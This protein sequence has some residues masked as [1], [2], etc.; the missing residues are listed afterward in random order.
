MVKLLRDDDQRAAS[1]NQHVKHD[2]MSLR[3]LQA[4]G[5]TVLSPRCD[6]PPHTHTHSHTSNT[7]PRI[8][9]H[10]RTPRVTVCLETSWDVNSANTNIKTEWCHCWYWSHTPPCVQSTHTHTHTHRRC[11]LSK[12]TNWVP[13]KSVHYISCQRH[14]KAVWHSDGFSAHVTSS[15]FVCSTWFLI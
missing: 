10:S 4:G 11:P 13:P 12:Q 3:R 6:P 14:M 7:P 2:V 1:W 5:D 9:T 15:V 8:I